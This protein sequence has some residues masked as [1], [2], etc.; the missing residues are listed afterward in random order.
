MRGNEEGVVHPACTGGFFEVYAVLG[1][2]FLAIERRPNGRMVQQ[3]LC[4][5]IN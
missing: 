2:E 3:E 1:Q 5:L 4:H